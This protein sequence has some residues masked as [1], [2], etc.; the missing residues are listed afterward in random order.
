MA[1]VFYLLEIKNE[2]F[3]EV[4]KNIHVVSRKVSIGLKD[5]N[6]FTDVIVLLK[7]IKLQ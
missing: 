3:P 7:F 5:S 2:M 4:F 6:L 1:L